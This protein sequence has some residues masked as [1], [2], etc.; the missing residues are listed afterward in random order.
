MHTTN[1]LPMRDLPSLVEAVFDG[2]KRRDEIDFCRALLR[3]R[4]DT[5]DP[6]LEARRYIHQHITLLEAPIEESLKLRL[7]LS[8]YCHA[9]AIE[10]LYTVTGNLLRVI[11]GHPHAADPFAATAES[12]ACSTIEGKVSRIAEWATAVELEEFGDLLTEMIV[13]EVRNA[14]LS[15]IYSLDESRFFYRPSGGADRDKSVLPLEWILPR[16]NR[17]VAL[18]L[19]FI[20][21]TQRHL[22]AYQ[23]NRILPLKA[24]SGPHTHVELIGRPGLGLIG[25]RELTGDSVPPEPAGPATSETTQA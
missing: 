22:Q 9:I 13:P 10:D 11:G 15:S 18:A 3:G 8:L 21:A 5:V 7:M 6:L 14:F 20:D 1:D 24:P 23:A 2:A 12:A 4:L 16:L 25:L 17:G 19:T